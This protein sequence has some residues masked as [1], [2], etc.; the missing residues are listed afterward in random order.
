MKN[1]IDQISTKRTIQSLRDGVPSPDHVLDYTSDS[2][3]I[4]SPVSDIVGHLKDI[5]EGLS[6]AEFLRGDYGEGKSHALSV[7]KELALK[8][9]FIVS[10]FALE[11]RGTSFDFFER[12]LSRLIEVMAVRDKRHG[13]EGSVLDHIIETWAKKVNDIDNSEQL[14]A[15]AG[16]DYDLDDALKLYGKII[17]GQKPRLQEGQ[18]RIALLNRWFRR[19]ETGLD[20]A[21]RRL[22]HVRDNI[23]S[24]NA[25]TILNQLA[26]FF[27]EIGFSGWVILI[28]E[29]EIIPT[30]MSPKKRDSCNQNLRIVIDSGPSTSYLYYLFATS[31]EFFTDQKRGINSYPALKD[32]VKKYR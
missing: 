19:G 27:H 5:Q 28:D 17:T 6:I 4:E 2:Y 1:G 13:D 14:R 11:R 9:N 15:I 3:L 18:D 30:L 32:R 10:Q 29:Q 8:E 26:V 12:I 16:R 7:I 25:R 31:P 20:A 23:T 21:E 22:I 24:R